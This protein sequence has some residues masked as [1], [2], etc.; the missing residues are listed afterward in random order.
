[1]EG[2][3]VP[4]HVIGVAFCYIRN[5]SARKYTDQ[6]FID[7]VAKS[8][9]IREALKTL[10]LAPAGGSYKIFHNRVKQLNISTKHFTG[11]S[12]LKGKIHHGHIKTPLDLVLIKE[13][14]YLNSCNLKKRLIKEELLVN[15][16]NRCKIKEWQDEPLSLHLDHIDGDNTNNQISNLRL[17]C[18][19]CHSQTPTYCGRNKKKLVGMKGL[20]PSKVSIL[21]AH[22]VPFAINPHTHSEINCS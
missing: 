17:L 19:N 22:A 15:E 10:G 2:Q 5:M 13:S 11:Q 6:Q 8:F 7:A 21:S 12:Y 3:S 20:E 14:P 4:P 16:C 9:S 18:P 1:M